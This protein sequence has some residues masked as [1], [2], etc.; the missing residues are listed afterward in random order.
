M[1]VGA[2]TTAFGDG[3]AATGG[4]GG[5]TAAGGVT[6]TA[7]R[8]RDEVEPARE[9][10]V[11]PRHLPPLGFPHHVVANGDQDRAQIVVR[12]AQVSDQRARK[13]GVSRGPIERHVAG[14]GGEADEGA[15]PGL[16]RRQAAPDI[17]RACAHGPREVGRER[18]VA[19]RVEEQDVGGRLALHC[20]LHEIKPH[21][22][23]IERRR[24]PQLRIDRDQVVGARYLQTVSGVEEHADIRADERSGEIADFS[25]E[26]G[27]VEIDPVEDL[28]AVHPQGGG[29]VDRIVAC[30]GQLARMLVRRVTDHQRDAL[31]CMGR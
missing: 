25:L 15:D 4:D 11:L 7:G 29:H 13:R 1:I 2:R 16:S 5:S 30:V 10:R 9:R 23:E 14:L 17:R 6:A 27:L 3:S 12:R 28:K 21:H 18:V 26:R 20:P 22:L 24:A 8:A 31:A 19:A